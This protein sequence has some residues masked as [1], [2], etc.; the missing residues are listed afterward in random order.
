V[1]LAA[2]L[3]NMKETAMSENSSRNGGR[4]REVL[5]TKA[6]AFFKEKVD[7]NVATY[8]QMETER[9]QSD[10]KIAKLRALRLAK[11]EAEAEEA[12]IAAANEPAPVKKKKPIVINTN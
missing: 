10:N 8:Q 2:C 4:D 7:R 3:S 11:E 9:L 6:A 12:R 5:R 1:I